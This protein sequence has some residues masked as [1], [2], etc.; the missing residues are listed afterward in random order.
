MVGLA[1]RKDGLNVSET[2]INHMRENSRYL[3]LLYHKP[4]IFTSGK[5]RA[6]IEYAQLFRL[7]NQSHQIRTLQIY[8]HT[9]QSAQAA[10]MEAAAE[11]LP[12]K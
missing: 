8:A 7:P 6:V 12:L 1:Q 9:F 2:L 10:A 3:Y 11:A 5:W 4:P